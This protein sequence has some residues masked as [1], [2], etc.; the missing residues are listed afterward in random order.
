M[1]NNIWGKNA[2]KYSGSPPCPEDTDSAEN[3]LSSLDVDGM[4]ITNAALVNVRVLE[5]KFAESNFAEYLSDSHSSE[6]EIIRVDYQLWFSPDDIKRGN[7]ATWFE[8]VLILRSTLHADGIMSA[9]FMN[10]ISGNVF[11]DKAS[12]A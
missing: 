2:L 7:P 11:E 9:P 1:T 6:D 3:S 8:S 10:T 5:R 12:L 4:E